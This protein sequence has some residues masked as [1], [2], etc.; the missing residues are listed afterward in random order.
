MNI[1]VLAYETDIAAK[2]PTAPVSVAIA[3]ASGRTLTSR[4]KATVFL[5]YLV[6]ELDDDMPL[7]SRLVHSASVCMYVFCGSRACS[8]AYHSFFATPTFVVSFVRSLYRC[9]IHPFFTTQA[10]LEDEAAGLVDTGDLEGAR[11]ILA[12]HT[13][14]SAI[15]AVSSYHT[16]FDTL[17]ARYHDGYQ[18]QVGKVKA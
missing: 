9:R 18:M 13:N 12:H 7:R 3:V 15:A 1:W 5:T 14:D 16:L 17:V 2:A 6:K 10:D 4:T 8:E 11:S